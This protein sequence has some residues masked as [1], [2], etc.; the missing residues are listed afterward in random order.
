MCYFLRVIEFGIQGELNIKADSPA[1]LNKLSCFFFS[2]ML[3][4]AWFNNLA[5]SFLSA[6]YFICYN[7][8]EVGNK[9]RHNTH[10]N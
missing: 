10:G 8:R 4:T 5:V 9:D 2:V 3:L 6:F 7:K 1:A